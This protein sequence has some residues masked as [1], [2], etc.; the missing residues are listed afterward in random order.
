MADIDN[1][2][3]FD[4]LVAGLSSED[5][6]AMLKRIN[7][8][9]VKSVSISPSVQDSQD[10][11]QSLKSKL[12]NESILYKIF[13]WIRSIF[14]KNTQEVIYNED[15]LA[16]LAKK[17]NQKSPG[18]VNHK[19]K[20]LD[21]LFYERLNTLKEISDFFKPYFVSVKENPG[22]F[23]VFLSSFVAPQ[24]SESIN[25]DADPFTIPVSKE[26]TAELR[27]E[28]SRKLDAILK[29]MDNNTRSTIYS[30]VVQVNWLE[31]FTSVSY[32]HFLAQFTNV[33]G[34]TYTAPYKT[35]LLDFNRFASVGVKVI[36]IQVEVLEALFLFSQRKNFNHK[37]QDQ[38]IEKATKEFL[39]RANS[40]LI[41][42]QEFLSEMFLYKLGRVISGDY[43]W[44]PEA[45][46][47]AEGWFPLFRSQWRKIID[48]RWN[49]WLKAQKKERLSEKLR[50]DFGLLEF[51]EM[52]YSPW[53]KLW[54]T[55]P[56]GCELTGGFLS[57]FAT[58]KYSD[59]ILTLNVVSM[60][61]IFI[62]SENRTEYSEAL[63]TFSN[64]NGDIQSLLQKLS[65]SGS[66]GKV[67][68]DF[69]E[70]QVLTAQ[71]Q[72]QISAMM[73]D[74]ES[75]V[76]NSIKLFCSAARILEKI[77]QG[78]FDDVKDGVHEGLQNFTSIHG[79]ENAKYRAELSEARQLIK[80]TLFYISELEPIDN[81]S[82]Q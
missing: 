69:A 44:E 71:V 32:L 47:G 33:Q 77:F 67:F 65:P 82:V 45:M 53:K 35:C 68:A 12:N 64:A 20:V 63:N 78:F 52:Q 51:P 13:L 79:R 8:N 40:Y 46:Q 22:E 74:I 27:S 73:V 48:I 39:S 43:D 2:H 26:P 36:P 42:I 21:Y 59:I 76:K 56:F 38:D 58:E 10:N 25:K 70:N 81:S 50:F 14:Q 9:S 23:Y 6:I 54:K 19:L 49:D 18:I 72:N 4:K 28:L 66:Y 57:W 15:L 5:R 1:K 7:L 3:A 60:E 30:S 31:Q 16:N 61:G 62:K 80:E 29:D 41:T 17:I 37:I 75:I 34:Q 24:L 11:Y 55:I